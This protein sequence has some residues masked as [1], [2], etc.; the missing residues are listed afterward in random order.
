[1]GTAGR[2]AAR[3]CCPVRVSR[4]DR[5]CCPAP[6]SAIPSGPVSLPLFLLGAGFNADAA[7]EVASFGDAHG[8]QYPLVGDLWRICFDEATPAST[9]SIEDRFAVELS[10]RNYEPIKQL[11][12]TLMH[13]DYYLAATLSDRDTGAPNSYSAFFEAFPSSRYLTFNYDSLPEIFLYRRSLWMPDDGFGI[14]VV[15]EREDEAPPV[16]PSSATRVVHLHGSMYVYERA[17]DYHAKQTPGDVCIELDPLHE[18]VFHFDPDRMGRIFWPIRRSRTLGI[19]EIHHRIIAP[20]PD[21]TSGLQAAFVQ[22]A[23]SH[24]S[25]AIIQAN[26][27]IVVGYSFNQHDRASYAPLVAAMARRQVTIVA[28]DADDV[29]R[30]LSKEYP[31]VGWNPIPLRFGQWAARRFG[32]S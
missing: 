24:A 6:P 13:A 8:A 14:P 20:V 1:M 27:V 7:G 28:P 10:R 3:G 11:C 15:V 31:S 18:P 32:T 19:T 12:H 29:V 9:A 17:V 22:A 5:P 30:H 25:S 4:G 23:Y 21:K 16:I 2:P 26:Q